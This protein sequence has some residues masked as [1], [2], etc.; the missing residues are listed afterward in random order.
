[1]DDSFKRHIDIREDDKVPD[2]LEAASLTEKRSYWSGRNPNQG[3]EIH[4]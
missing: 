1:M 4:L 3:R 2:Y